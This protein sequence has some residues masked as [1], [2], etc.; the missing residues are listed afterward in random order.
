M[1]NITLSICIP[2][3]NRARYLSVLLRTLQDGLLNFSYS[4]QIVIS[5]N[6]STDNTA[7]VVSAFF[8]KLPIKYFK[9]AKNSNAE[10]NYLFTLDHAD[11]ILLMYLADDDM[12]DF[13]AL[14][15]AVGVML[16]QPDAVALYAPWRLFDMVNNK[17]MG[18]FYSQP[19]DLM[20]GKNDHAGLVKHVVQHGVWPEISIVRAD[21]FRR[22]RPSINPL[23][24]WAF[25]IP[26]EYLSYGHVIFLKDTFYISITNY[27]AD[28]SRT[29]NGH[30]EVLDAWDRYRGGWEYMLARAG[31]QLSD[32]DLTVL[33][34]GIERQVIGRMQVALRLRW[35][36]QKD[37]VESYFL[38]SRL[39]G[40]GAEALLP[41]PFFDIRSKAA[42]W[43]LTHDNLLTNEVDGF[44]CV[45]EFDVQILTLLRN[46]TTLPVTLL[47]VFP[48]DIE[49]SIVL[50]KG[51]LADHAINLDRARSRGNKIVA[52]NDLARKFY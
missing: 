24:Y 35:H 18:Y 32:N 50:L 48:D 16:S 7:E 29:Q 27:F 23:A 40:L 45:G 3:F 5:D 30:L 44:C 51:E 38:A 39:R 41:A 33:R 49:R 43:F 14:A 34:A 12:L 1:N 8:D 2:T 13:P 46:F 19:D 52:E 4:Y 9:Q 26:C 21:L 42:F 22:A 37:P 25:T 36:G 17:H 31:N 47:L 6:A 10:R 20:V 15:R 28:D 11:G